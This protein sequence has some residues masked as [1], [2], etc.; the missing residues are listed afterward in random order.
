VLL[1][2][3]YFLTIA[4]QQA[5]G[6]VSAIRNEELDITSIQGLIESAGYSVA[7]AGLYDA[8]Q[9]LVAMTLEQTTSAALG[10]VGSLPGMFIGLLHTLF[11]LFTLLRDRKDLVAWIPWVLP[12]DQEM[13]DA[14][15]DGVDRL[16]WA[17]AVG[18]IAV[19]APHAVLLG[20]G[21]RSPVSPR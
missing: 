7:L 16:M 20:V 15:H 10:L 19:A 17:S 5:L 2:L 14:L 6:V 3:I 13:L 4:A 1:P 18:N 21:Q 12:A 11:A 8:N 9:G